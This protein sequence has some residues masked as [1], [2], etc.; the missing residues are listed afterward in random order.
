MTYT[1]PE[2]LYAYCHMFN[3]KFRC[4]REQTKGPQAA[5]VRCDKWI[6][7]LWIEH[8][9]T[10]G[11]LRQEMVE[12]LNEDAWKAVISRLISVR[13]QNLW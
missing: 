4:I 13:P 2:T 7:T 11:L 10:G 9:E 3:V 1:D 6:H 8:P 5:R 12:G